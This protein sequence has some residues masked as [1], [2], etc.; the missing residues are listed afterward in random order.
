MTKIAIVLFN[1]GGPDNLNSVRKFLFN[2]FNDP[3][4]IGLPNPFR[5]LL[6]H[7]ISFR[8]AKV[9]SKIYQ[10]IGGKS[11]ILEI[12]NAQAEALEKELSFKGEFKVFVSMRY[13]HPMSKEVVAKLNEYQPDEIILLPLYPQF[14]T[15]TSASSM[16]DFMGE[17][18]KQKVSAPVKYVCCY[19]LEAEFIRAHAKLIKQSIQKAISLGHPNHRI[20]FSAHGLP[21]SVIA[22]GDP[23]VF[24]IEASTK[25]IIAELE[26]EN[27]AK[28]KIDYRICYQSKVG[29]VAWTTPSLEFEI[30]RAA[31]EKKPL[32]IVPIAFTSDHSETLVELDI[33]YKEIAEHKKIPLYLRVPALNS[34]GYFIKSLVDISLRALKSDVACNGGIEGARICPAK[35]GKCPNENIAG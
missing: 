17:L 33:E 32:I 7:L 30:N 22:K 26:K 14:S 31:I 34:D 20:L 16:L 9:A 4:I 24:Q 1:L 19:P 28:N 11:P 23:Y 25:A 6:A 15:T 18:K 12:T 3:A 21:K 29:P 35:F 13:W 5:Y 8:R 10:L 2:L 27:D